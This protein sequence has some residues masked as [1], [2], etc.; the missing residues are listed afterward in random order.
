MQNI[1]AH[2]EKLPD[3]NNTYE[4]TSSCLDPMQWEKNKEKVKY[5]DIQL[6]T[7]GIIFKDVRLNVKM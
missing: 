2:A 5:T 4:Y 3:K 6:Q 7:Y 1:Q